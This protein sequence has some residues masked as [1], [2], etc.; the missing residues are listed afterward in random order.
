MNDKS[1]LLK[2]LA[3]ERD[4]P[5][6]NSRRPVWAI[7]AAAAALIVVGVLG[8][9]Y[10][11]AR[12]VPPPPSAPP[13]E[14][15]P[16]APAEGATEPANG[17]AGGQAMSTAAA[18]GPQ[19]VLNASGYITARRKAT[20]SS[21]I[22]GRIEAVLIEEGMTVKEGQIVARLDDSLARIDLGLAEARVRVAE[23]TLKGIE[24]D[25]AEA[26]RV[27]ARVTRLA[28]R[29][30]AS[31]A[32]RTRAEAQVETLSARLAGARADL[33]VARLQV[34]RRKQTVEDHLVRAPFAGVVVDKSA[35]PGEIVSPVSAGGGFT[36]TGICTV[37]DM[38]SLEIEVDVNEAFIGRVFPDQKVV[39]TLDAYPDWQIPASVIA[40]VPTANRQKATVK[41]RIRIEQRDPRILPDMGVK[42]AFLGA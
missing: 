27:L 14:T 12:K 9:Y 42:V 21:K 38:D 16:A 19:Q 8:G 36:R 26:R 1:D 7:A 17:E 22:T 6:S 35:Q 25:L 31:E 32:D 40:I 5:Q 11:G 39:A 15:A 29:G 34:K 10:L 41:V 4:S 28:D 30:N 18:S 23:A 13:G 2:R 24:A 37:V 20:V 33:E 3:I